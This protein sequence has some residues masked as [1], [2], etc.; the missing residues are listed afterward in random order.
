MRGV[1]LDPQPAAPDGGSQPVPVVSGA[2]T[3][4]APLRD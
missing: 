4:P 3:E 1:S 2:T